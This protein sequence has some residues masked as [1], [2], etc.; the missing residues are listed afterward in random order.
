M[1]LSWLALGPPSAC[2]R[3]KPAVGAKA[4]KNTIKEAIEMKRLIEI[5]W[6]LKAFVRVRDWSQPNKHQ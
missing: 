1:R 2:V 5:I 3:G 4:F 6:I